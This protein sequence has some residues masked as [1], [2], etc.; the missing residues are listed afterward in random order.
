MYEET[1]IRTSIGIMR[2]TR[3]D[4]RTIESSAEKR[5]VDQTPS[6][7]PSILEEFE[8]FIVIIMSTAMLNC[9]ITLVEVNK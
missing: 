4:L 2:E 9:K 7:D 5:L 3:I 8:K 1:T 6:R